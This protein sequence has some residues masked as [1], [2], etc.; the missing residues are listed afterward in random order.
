MVTIGTPN[1]DNATR[2][3]ILGANE[4]S[5]ETALEAQRLGLEVIAVDGQEDAPAMQVAHRSHVIHMRDS[6][7]LQ[8]LIEREKPHNIIP[9]TDFVC[10]DTLMAAE[11]NGVVVAPTA[12]A[13]KLG[14]DRAGIRT[15]VAEELS[16]PTSPYRIATNMADYWSNIGQIGFPCVVKPIQSSSGMGHSLL[17]GDGDTMASWQKAQDKSHSGDCGVI[18]EGLVEFDYE[19]TLLVVHH[20]AGIDFCAPIGHRKLTANYSE[21]WQPHSM[22]GAALEQA[23]NYARSIVENLGGFGLFSFEFFVKDGGVFFSKVCSRPHDTGMVTF[24]SQNL[25][26]CALHLRAVLGLSIPGI[27]SRGAAAAA[28]IL[29]EGDGVATYDI[30]PEALSTPNTDLRLFGKQ[31]VHGRRPMGVALALGDD[32]DQARSRAVKLAEGVTVKLS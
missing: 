11:G 3:L 13:A 29:A 21:S 12:R 2:V 16:I 32:V 7:E 22:D 14:C 30:S 8:A 19:V 23:Q 15:L 1:T 10:A 4:I 25:S 31:E 6:A 5:K 28:A 26:Q 9:A 20:T 24:A 18:I 17:K 27:V